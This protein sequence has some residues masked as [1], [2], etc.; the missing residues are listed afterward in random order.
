MFVKA[1]T[2]G[3]PLLLALARIPEIKLLHLSRWVSA[4]ES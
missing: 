3:Y 2:Y 1:Q 4:P